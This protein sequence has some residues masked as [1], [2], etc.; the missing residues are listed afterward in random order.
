MTQEPNSY[1]EVPYTSYPYVRTHPDHLATIGRLFGMRPVDVAGARV[2]EL[3]CASGGNLIPMAEQL[4]GAELVGV[5]LSA[6]QIA[7]GQ[8]AVESLGLGNVRLVHADLREVDEALGTF[9]YVLCH[10]VF[11]WVPRDV[12]ER[13][14]EIC[15]QR[16][17]PQGIGFISYNT[18]PGWH[19]RESVRHMMR[20]HV[21]QFEE[22]KRR[23]EQAGALLDFLASAVADKGDP[24]GLLLQRE[25]QILARTND[26]YL[27][28]EHLEEHNHPCYF[29][30][31]AERLVPHQLQYL[32]E[33]DVPTML[34]RELSDDVAE[35]LGRI[36][37]DLLRLEQYMDFVRNRQ[38][39]QTLVCHA[40]VA[41]RRA[42]GPAATSGLWVGFAASNPEEPVDLGEGTVHAFTTA[43]GQVINTSRAMTK[44]ALQ[45]AARAWPQVLGLRELSAL[46]AGN[47]RGVG[48]Q[49]DAGADEA[50]AADLLS[51]FFSGSVEL[52]T[53]P[54]AAVRE[55]GSRPAVSG[56]ARW[57]A[58]RGGFAA[59]R[60]HLRVDLDQA[61]RHI[62]AL[63]DGTNDRAAIA[64]RLAELVAAGTL[65]LSLDD[66]AITDTSV[67]E[68]ALQAIVAQSLRNLAANAM[69]VA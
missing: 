32:G 40:D 44:A 65:R 41:L 49:P 38:F 20:W 54:I 7:Q 9:D 6:R 68:E 16:L 37:P 5:D 25:L 66:A 43:S 67:A 35:T 55:A 36:A 48:I 2:L 11:S 64:S 26:D 53:G 1:D 19:L 62:V 28:H 69:L 59:S 63:L 22:A 34:P 52:R 23:T 15:A 10:G 13:I 58:E 12:Q 42:V 14:L 27:F 30:E 50:L 29:H 21:S 56:Y 47:V 39:R 18:Y 60:R 51:C 33:A 61:S 31:L 57:Q 8:E 24:F 45:I 3:G 17:S 4:P 46:A